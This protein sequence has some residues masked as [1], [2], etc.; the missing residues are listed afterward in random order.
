MTKITI[1]TRTSF[2]TVQSTQKKNK[3]A[4]SSYAY[5]LIRDKVGTISS[6]KRHITKSLANHYIL[7]F[8]AF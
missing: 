7:L 1:R 3:Y 6:L 8:I 4:I 2:A 5:I